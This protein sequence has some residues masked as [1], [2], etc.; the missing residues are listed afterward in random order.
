MPENPAPTTTTLTRCSQQHRSPGAA[1]Q[2]SLSRLDVVFPTFETVSGASGAGTDLA[3]EDRLRDGTH[4]KARDS[5]RLSPEV[6]TTIVV[7]TVGRPS[8]QS[9][10]AAL[11]TGS[12]PVTAPVVLVDDRPEPDGDLDV[13]TRDLEVRVVRSGGGGPARARNVGWRASRTAW[14][15]F[16]DEDVLPDPDWY[17]RL[18]ADLAAASPDTPRV[19]GRLQV[20]RP[21][22]TADLSYRRSA[23]AA[24]GGFDER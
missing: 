3:P 14:V 7:P 4:V 13:G 24:V 10:L 22:V 12:V 8:L 15:S 2:G 5:N 17:A 6:A 19:P 20:P 23:L 11:A 9:L 21:R 16:L 1:G 18:L